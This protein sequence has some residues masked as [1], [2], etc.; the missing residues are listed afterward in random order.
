MSSRSSSPAAPGSAVRT[1]ERNRYSEVLE[2]FGDGPD[3]LAGCTHVPLGDP[4]GGVVVC[5]P[6]FNEAL[7]NFR[8]EVDL[9]RALAA[10]G[11]ATQ[12]FS[13]RGSGNSDGVP[14][15]MTFEALCDDARAA[16]QRLRENAGVTHPVF[17]GTRF[18]AL[19]AAA[20]AAGLDDA[21]LVLIEPV[22]AADRFFAEGLRA[23]AVGDVV[24]QSRHGDAAAGPRSRKEILEVLES[25]GRI[26]IF[27]FT[28][29]RDLYRSSAGR[30]LEGVLGDRP[31][32]ILAVQ[33]G[34]ERELGR[35]LEGAGARWG[36]AGFDVEVEK[37]G[38]TD[39]WW[40]SK[41][42]EDMP[43]DKATRRAGLSEDDP[44][45][46][47]VQAWVDRHAPGAQP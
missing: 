18:G 35:D 36:E 6:L 25:T 39:I 46:A 4:I 16:T 24:N 10:R 40:L 27:G 33:L 30:T 37:A 41:G 45:L 19:V 2:F 38:V 47:V 32:P 42:G 1:D 12:R 9:S 14:E 8:R 26:D 21:P 5:S 44:V 15:A 11:F 20:V 29:G 17:L 43:T 31:R 13:Y 7:K 23:K 34:A 22:L 3:R 28:L